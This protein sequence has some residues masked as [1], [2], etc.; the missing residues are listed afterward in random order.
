MTQMKA[1]TATT[2]KGRFRKFL[3]VI[4]DVETGGFNPATDA[5][6]EIAAVCIG[7]DEQGVIYP[8]ITHHYHIQPFSGANIEKSALEFTGIDPYHPFRF[9]VTEQKGLQEL[10]NVIRAQVK[11][12]EC[13]RAIL[14]GHNA[15]F[16]LSFVYAAST[17]AKIKR[18]P[19]HPF[20]VLD[21]VSLSA[22]A[23]GETVLARA[24]KAANLEYNPKEA[25]SALYD[26]Q[27][28]A[29]LFCH[30]INQQKKSLY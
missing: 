19:F 15:H 8:D 12:H 7:M 21:T 26:A 16:D 11:I 4:I 9:S 20:S 22:L 17:R 10:F 27:R 23:L 3:P 28:T 29:A 14:V 1:T 24:L 13:Q 5:L 30:I 6:L 25:H 2:L 18:N